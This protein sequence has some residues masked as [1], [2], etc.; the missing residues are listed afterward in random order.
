MSRDALAARPDFDADDELL[1]ARWKDLSPSPEI[2]ARIQERLPPTPPERTLAAEWLEL[3]RVRPI[4][5]G[6]MTLAAA[7][8]L[9]LATPLAALGG[10]L[11]ALA[12]HGE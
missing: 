2:I 7:A 6:A 3:L 11:G 5:H 1:V 8:V 12:K 9:M 4:V 10:I